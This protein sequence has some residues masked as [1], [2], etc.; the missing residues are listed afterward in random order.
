MLALKLLYGQTETKTEFNSSE[1]AR[2]E[3]LFPG[4]T[5]SVSQFILS[6][7]TAT[8]KED[9]ST[10]FFF[11]HYKRLFGLSHSDRRTRPIIVW[12]S[13]LASLSVINSLIAFLSIVVWMAAKCR[14][15]ERPALYW[16]INIDI[17]D[18]ALLYCYDY[19]VDASRASDGSNTI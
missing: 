6:N 1:M 14:W 16:W 19:T 3:P 13:G 7:K 4:Q 15:M 10:H 2:E 17:V 12:M 9:K 8:K 18:V 11:L 5:T